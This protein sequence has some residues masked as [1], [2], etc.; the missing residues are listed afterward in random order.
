MGECSCFALIIFSTE[1][2]DNKV[3]FGSSVERKMFPLHTMPTRLGIEQGIQGEPH[4]G[5]GCYDDDPV[6]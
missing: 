5:P 6:R 4:R 2:L 1:K 3:A